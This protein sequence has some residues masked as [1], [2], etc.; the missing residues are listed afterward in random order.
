MNDPREAFDSLRSSYFL[1]NQ[2]D[3]KILVDCMYDLADEHPGGNTFRELADM[4]LSTYETLTGP[5]QKSCT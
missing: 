4:I 5:F 1:P 3:A 2:V